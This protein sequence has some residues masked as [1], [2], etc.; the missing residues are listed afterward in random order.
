[1]LVFSTQ[2]GKQV[3]CYLKS[4]LNSGKKEIFDFKIL[5][6]PLYSLLKVSSFDILGPMERF[7]EQITFI[8]DRLHGFWEHEELH[9]KIS[10]G[11][12][13]LF[14]FSL[15]VIE[16]NRRGLLPAQAGQLIPENHFHA[17]QAAF[18]VILI[19]EVISLIFV[20]PCSFSRSVGKQFEILA[21]ILMRNA[22]K[23]LAYFPE[24][25]TFAGNQDKV[26]HI[27]ADGFGALLI[28]ALLGLYYMLQK[29]WAK[30]VRWSSELFEFVAAKKAISMVLLTIFIGM[31]SWNLYANALGIA[32]TDFFQD[33]YTVLIIT[34]ILIVLVAQC[35][36]PSA[37]SIFRNS[38]YALSTMIIRL[39][40]VAPVYYNVLLG[41]AAVIFAISLTFISYRLFSEEP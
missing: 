6:S 17:V 28:F 35:F 3:G 16:L 39:A 11:L 32:Q 2:H 33:F 34:D 12:V 8:F 21:L 36:N 24:P 25:I 13:L 15:F 7:Y 18:V 26:L 30:K 38:G 5:F 31:G 41:T 29:R 37:S 4:F 1:M 10:I 14:L 40:L 27:L 20:L 22:F 9:R 23:E 19:L